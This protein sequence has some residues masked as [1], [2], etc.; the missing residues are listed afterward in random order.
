[1]N[2]LYSYQEDIESKKKKQFL[3]NQYYGERFLVELF[4]SWVKYIFSPYKKD[5]VSF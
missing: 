1:M 2:L 5:N 4:L 3:L